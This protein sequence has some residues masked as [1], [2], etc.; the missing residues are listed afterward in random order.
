[1]I[2]VTGAAGFIGSC[3]V[4]KLNALGRQDLLVVDHYENDQDASRRNLANKKYV[5]FYDKA[6][7]L[8]LAQRDNIDADVTC[9]F[10]MGA[11][12]S[13]T[14]DD[15][16]Y[17]QKN[18]Y[19]YSIAMAQWAWK[20]QVRFIYASSA[21]TYG[22][23]QQGY[24][25]NE[26]VLET[27][28]PL[29]LYGDSKH[30]FDLWV[31]QQGFLRRCAGLKFFNVFGPNEYHKGDMQSVIAK[32]YAKVRDQGRMLLFKSH[33]P[34]YKDGEQKRDFVYVKDVV[35]VMLFLMEHKDVNG[36]FN[37]GTGQARSW[38]DVAHA[39]FSALHKT[40]QINYVDMPSILLDKYQYFTQANMG[41]LRRAGYSKP[42]TS[43]EDAVKDYC[44]YLSNSQVW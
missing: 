42:F 24:D 22:D 26:E 31:K 25:D 10:H 44:V 12:S 19:E 37:V 1:M 27:L 28:K 5:R 2:V 32:S 15:A 14:L 18:N 6:E 30:R 3:L 35:D 33:R 4:A 41:K 34:D 8:K 16:A 21:A 29:N 7:F 11:C 40:A 36:I 20:H 9:L 17:F 43:L 39:L 38:N 23:G 13:T